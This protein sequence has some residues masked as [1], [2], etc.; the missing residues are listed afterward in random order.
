MS[1]PTDAGL[2][3]GSTACY[4]RAVNWWSRRPGHGAGLG[5]EL[6]WFGEAYLSLPGAA[7]ERIWR[8]GPTG[9]ERPIW[10]SRRRST[11]SLAFLRSPITCLDRRILYLLEAN[12]LG[13][14]TRTCHCTWFRRFS[15]DCPSCSRTL[16]AVKPFRFRTQ[17]PVYRLQLSFNRVL[18]QTL[19]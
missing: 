5:L 14:H 15:W 17:E 10:P 1:P 6:L 11:E 13:C 8:V 7:R 12:S 16:T 9:S 3:L 19:K 18:L 4:S 2:G